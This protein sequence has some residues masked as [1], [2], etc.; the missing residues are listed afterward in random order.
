M[1]RNILYVD[2]VVDQSLQFVLCIWGENYFEAIDNTKHGFSK[3]QYTLGDG[4]P[5]R[6][7]SI[8]AKIIGF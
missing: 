3:L 6:Q 4:S 2:G 5:R 7:W 8:R 1:T